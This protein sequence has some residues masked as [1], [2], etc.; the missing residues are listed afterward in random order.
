MSDTGGNF[1]LDKCKQFCKNLNIEQAT[2]SS[3]HHQSIGQIEA[4]IKFIKFTIKMQ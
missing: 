3:N 2:S 4:C 1:V